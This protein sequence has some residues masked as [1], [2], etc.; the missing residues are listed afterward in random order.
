MTI[1]VSGATGFIGRHFVRLALEEEVKVLAVSRGSSAA[2]WSHPN[3]RWLKRELR[4]VAPA[5]VAGC[6]T[7]VHLAAHGVTAGT[8]EWEQCFRVNVMDS[9]AFWRTAVSAGIRRFVVCGSCF[10]YGRSGERYEK[11]PVDAPLE[12]TGAYHASKAAASMAALALAVEHKLELSLLRPFHVF[13]EGEAAT[14]LW[15]AL[16][17]AALAGGDFPM[18]A[19]EQVRDFTPVELVVARFL[20]HCRRPAIAGQPVV[21]NIGTGRPTSVRG[22][23]EEWWARWGARGRLLV[24]ALPYRTDEVMRYVPNVKITSNP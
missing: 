6:D 2:E 17:A 15:P 5:D 12:P 1:L 18:T 14:R 13:G 19:G 9:L 10:E 11:I 4:E 7:L 22:F 20:Q 3:L 16:R 24:G 23:S 21:E 8:N